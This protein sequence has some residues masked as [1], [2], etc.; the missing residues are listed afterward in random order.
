MASAN[1][2]FAIIPGKNDR[3]EH[4]FSVVVKRTYRI[5]QGS[6]LER[7]EADQELRKI[8]EYYDHGD[9]EWATVK[10]EYELAPY[11]PFVDVVVIGK[12]YA[13]QGKPIPQMTVS[14]R[15]ASRE[16]AIAVFGDR[17]CHYRGSASPVFSEPKPFTEMEIRY[18]HAYG[19][20]DD[21]SFP[22][23]PFFYPRNYMGTGI[24]LRNIKEVV[25]GMVLPNLEDPKD[26][27]TPERIILGQP[28]RWP[29]QPLP[30]GFGWFQRTWYPRCAFV[31]AY[32][33][34]VEVD[35]ATTEER[36][37]LLPRKPY[38]PR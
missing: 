2:V 20:W 25:Q 1:N 10:Y 21:K 29:S 24:A 36:L 34:Y 7:S 28:E 18:E 11:K 30:Q 27:L 26:L 8:D 16:K 38:C 5:N 6:A 22:E 9:P 17:E 19:G 35:T 12:A 32:P 13:P 15:V 33:P 23:I 4:I 37:G 14:V 31:G 3:G